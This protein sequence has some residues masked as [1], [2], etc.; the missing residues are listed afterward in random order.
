MQILHDRFGVNNKVF[1]DVG[2]PHAL[3]DLQGLQECAP[4]PVKAANGGIKR[5]LLTGE[6]LLEDP[7]GRFDLVKSGTMNEAE[8]EQAVFD[9]TNFLTYLAEPMA[10]QRKHIGRW[11]LLFLLLLLVPVVLLNREYWKGIH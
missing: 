6:D 1:K 10:E 3:L 8:Y 9:L 5:D 2:M 11:V 4:G 7:C